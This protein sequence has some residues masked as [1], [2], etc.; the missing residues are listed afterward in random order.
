VGLII[1]GGLL[2]FF[3]FSSFFQIKET[4]ISGNQEILTRDLEDII[5]NQITHRWINNFSVSRSIFL[6]NFK[7]ITKEILIK[8]PLVAKINLERSFP[9]IL[10]VK[11]EERKPVAVFTQKGNYFLV[12][13]E[14]V[15]FKKVD[16]VSPELLEIENLS[17]EKEINLGE[18][19]IEKEKLIQI[20]EI[21]SKIR[22]NLKISIPK[23]SIISDKRLNLK[24]SENWEIYFDSSQ[25]L[26]W[27][28]T[29]LNLVLEKEIPLEK[30][31]NLEYIDL[32]FSRVYYKYKQ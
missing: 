2:Y 14:G 11:V 12:D 1:I 18:K 19:I 21:E 15:I 5:E 9:D 27:Q 22:E 4:K 6:T 20:L 28:T 24:T 23:I 32:R 26:N 25:D 13:I 16:Q 10:I 8:F 29:K 7:K 17:S 3:I 30:R 31:G